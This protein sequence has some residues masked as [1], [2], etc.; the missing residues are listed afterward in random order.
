MVGHPGRQGIQVRQGV[1]DL[2]G[3]DQ[4]AGVGQGG[5]SEGDAGDQGRDR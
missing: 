2:N 5:H 1:V 3:D 4:F